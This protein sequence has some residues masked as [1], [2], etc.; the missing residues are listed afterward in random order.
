MNV[1]KSFLL[2]FTNAVVLLGLLLLLEFGFRLSVETHSDHQNFR[3]TQ[4]AP[5]QNAPFFSKG[6]VVES[7]KQPG[8]WKIPPGTNLIIPN[9]FKGHYFT[10]E[11]GI[12]RTTNVP[13]GATRDIYLFGGSTVYNSEVPDDYTIASYLQRRLVRNGFGSYRVTNLGVTSVSTNQQFE[14]LKNTNISKDDI[15]VFYDGVNDVVQGVLY[16]NAGNT[17]YGN[18]KSRP[19]WQKTL[20]KIADHSVAVRQ[21]LSRMNAN[22]KI[23]NL[24]S[25][26][27]QTVSRYRAHTEGAQEVANAHGAQFIHFLQPSLY[28]LSHRGDYENKLLS[29]G[30]IPMQAEE[31]FLATYPHLVRY[32]RERSKLGFADFDLTSIFDNVAQPVYLDFC[33]VNHNGN[34]I[35][36]D[37]I[38]AALLKMHFITP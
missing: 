34:E 14:R 11:G 8:G 24:G 22:Y 37:S 25:R 19:S 1:R 26:V 3:L 15:V 21:L 29:L 4:P 16:G 27:R 38:F 31:A 30:I 2:V 32:V 28:S 17:I 5:Y 36:A 12:R 18:D 20:S 9:D 33:H 10:V 6:F 23:T 35:I 7:F 13:L